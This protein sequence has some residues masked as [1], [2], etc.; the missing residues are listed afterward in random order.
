[1]SRPPA[2][3]LALQVAAFP[4]VRTVINTGFRMVYPFLPTI[5]RGLGVQ[6]ESVALAVTARSG[7][8][9]L[10][11]FFGTVADTRSRRTAMLLALCLYA[12]GMALVAAW[13]TYAAFF[14]ALLIS[15]TGKILFDSAMQAYLGDRVDYSRRGLVIAVTE[16]GWS[17]AFLIGM[18]VTGWLIAKAGWSAPFPWLAG[19]AL[20]AALFLW[21]LLPHE[22][23]AARTQRSVWQG[24]R[25]VV[26]HRP[27]LAGLAVSLLISAANELVNIVYGVWME[28]SFGLQ[29]AALGAASAV[30]GLSELVG[31]GLVATLA[32]R[33]GKRSAVAIGIA[34]SASASLALPVLG[35]TLTFSLIGLFLFYVCFEFTLVTGIS[36]MT[37]LVPGARATVMAGNLS[38]HAL[39]RAVGAFLGPLLFAGG[40]AANGA[41]SASLNVAA[42]ALL[43]VFVRE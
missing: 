6:V 35:R 34:L 17:G 9:L 4:V 27:A 14:A 16:F 40:I 10:A 30:I 18:P 36:L 19:L 2:D 41:V 7:L 32:D 11:P 24:M 15:A 22:A 23:P 12:A 43:L 8:G 25:A 38:A 20:A 3:R 29:I 37:E 28:G 39:G 26:S 1:M 5:A 31:E 33:L 42:I 21:R 13:P